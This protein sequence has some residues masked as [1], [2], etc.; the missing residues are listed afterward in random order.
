M[1]K[2]Q[3]IERVQMSAGSLYTREDVINLLQAI[4]TSD[5][6]DRAIVPALKRILDIAE[7]VK[8]CVNDFQQPDHSWV[9]YRLTIDRNNCVSVDS[10]TIDTNAAEDTMD[11]LINAIKYLI[12]DVSK[13]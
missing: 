1:N 7:N 12:A 5:D 10:L 6:S 3:V 9:D 8:E 11:T 4:T 13:S 2:Q